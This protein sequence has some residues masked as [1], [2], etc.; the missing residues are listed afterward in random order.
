MA[1]YA[2]KTA[3]CLGV[4]VQLEPSDIH[5][6]DEFVGKDYGIPTEAGMEAIALLA[7]NEGILVDVSYSGKAMSGL[8]D[9][10]RKGLYSPDQ[11]IVFIHTGGTPALFASRDELVE[12]IPPKQ[13]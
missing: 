13:R 6:T 3:E 2:T 7:R 4:D 10:V 8:I 11:D 9:H 12:M 1:R 5:V